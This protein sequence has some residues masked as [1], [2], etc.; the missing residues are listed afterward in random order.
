MLLCL[1]CASDCCT[2][3]NLNNKC[4]MENKF[5]RVRSIKDIVISVV[6]LV[7]GIVLVVVPCA[8][9]ASISGYILIITAVILLLALKTSYCELNTKELYFKKELLFRREMKDSILSAM[10]SSFDAIDKA[11]VDK[12]RVLLLRIYCGK[13]SGKAY[14]Q[15]FEYVPQE[16]KPCSEMLE[17]EIGKVES[18]LK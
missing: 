6:L 13:S 8:E 2:M 16:Y 10:K 11:E 15:L 5:I 12:G 14:V 3:I 18:L 7:F 9:A 4:K 17:L 1:L